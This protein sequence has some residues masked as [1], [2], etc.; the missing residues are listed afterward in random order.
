LV[1]NP[2]YPGLGE[3]KIS[4]RVLRNQGSRVYWLSAILVSFSFGI[5]EECSVCTREHGLEKVGIYQ[6]LASISVARVLTGQQGNVCSTYDLTVMARKQLESEHFNVM[7]S[8][9]Q[10][11]C[12]QGNKE[13]M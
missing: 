4:F 12:G 6:V 2:G 11:W 8:S 13:G 1:K 7:S 5:L 10:Q 9:L 3:S